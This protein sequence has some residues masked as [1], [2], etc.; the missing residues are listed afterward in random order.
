M[1]KLEKKYSKSERIVI[2]ARFSG[3]VFAREVSIAALFGGIIAVL[4]IFGSELE[5]L[6]G[7]SAGTVFNEINLR[8]TVLAAGLFVLLLLAL[9]ALSI[10]K[11][12]LIMTEDKI[13]YNS[14]VLFIKSVVLPVTEIKMV[15]S[16]QNIFQRIFNLGHLTIITDAEK[17]YFIKNVTAPEKLARR[18]M[19]QTT[20]VRNRESVKTIQL[21]VASSAANINRFAQY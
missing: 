19:K 2:K 1:K 8:W 6:M 15:E 13:A 5:S 7:L 4:W 17:P 16:D 18:I 12:E 10:Y 20:S 11:K 3:W 21:Q 9:H 14:G